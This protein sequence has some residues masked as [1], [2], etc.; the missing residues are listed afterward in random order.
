MN[1]AHKPLKTVEVT[2]FLS[3]RDAALHV[4]SRLNLSILD[5]LFDN[6]DYT[7]DCSLDIFYLIPNTSDQFS[8]C[9]TLLS[10]NERDPMP[11]S[12]HYTC[13]SLQT[14]IG[15]CGSKYEGEVKNGE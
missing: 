5:Q 3:F 10:V 11:T 1:A 8:S 15:A 7:Y 2:V 12:H 13:V 6:L 4:G 14:V 9:L